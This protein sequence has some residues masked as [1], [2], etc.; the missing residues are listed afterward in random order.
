M[1]A[2]RSSGML[3]PAC[4]SCARCERLRGILLYLTTDCH[5]QLPSLTYVLVL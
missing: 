2:T 5:W 3:V 1:A 4:I